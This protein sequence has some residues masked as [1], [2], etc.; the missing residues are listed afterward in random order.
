M[1]STSLPAF[2][3]LAL[4]CLSTAADPPA[5]VNCSDY[6]GFLALCQRTKSDN[7]TTYETRRAVF[8]SNCQQVN[9]NNARYARNESSYQSQLYCAFSDVPEE[10]KA[11]KHTLIQAKSASRPSNS[12]ERGRPPCQ[13]R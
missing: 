1:G 2:L 3:L 4:C 13:K 5:A 7:A 9:D 6:D 8:E 10:Q 12:Q 11:S